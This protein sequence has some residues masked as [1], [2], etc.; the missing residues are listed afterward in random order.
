MGRN[1]LNELY[2]IRSIPLLE[3]TVRQLGF[4]HRFSQV[5][6]VLTTERY[7]YL[8]LQV[9]FT[10]D[11]TRPFVFSFKIEDQTTLVLQIPDQ[12][13]VSYTM[14]DSINIGSVRVCIRKSPFDGVLPVSDDLWQYTYTPAQSVALE[15]AGRLSASWAEEG[16]GI[17]NLTLTG[18]SPDKERDFLAGHIKNY[19]SYDLEQKNQRSLNTIKFI[20]EQLKNISDSLDFAERQLE[21]FKGRNVITNLEGEALRLY[22][23]IE[24]IE[25]QKTELRVSEKYYQHLQDYISKNDALDKVILPSSIG[26]EDEILT[27]L[28]SEMIKLQSEL[29]ITVQR[30]KI[31]NPLMVQKRK[32]IE[33]LKRSVLESIVNQ[34]SVNKIRVAFFDDQLRDLERQVGRLP[35]AERQLVNI[36]RNYSLSENLYVFLLQKRADAGI[37]KASNTTDIVEVNPPLVSGPI[38]P[39]TTR[40]NL[41]W[42]ALGLMLPL[43]VL[44][45]VEL[46]NTRVQS[47]EDIEKATSIPFLG[48]VGHKSGDQNLEVFQRP[49]SAISESFR[50]LRSNLNYFL[51][52]KEKG[53]FLIS[54]SVSGE[55]KTFTSVNLAAVFALSGRKT[56]I[57]GA[58]MRKPRIYSDFKLTNDFGLSNFLAGLMSFDEVVQRTAYNNLDLVSGGPVPPN[59]SELLL[60][61]QMKKF[62]DEARSRYDYVFIDSPPLALVTDAFVLSAV[63]DHT[64]FIIRQ[65]VTP[66]DLIRTIDDYYRAGKIS[67]I[68][69]VL[70]DIYKSGPGYGYGY[71]HGYGYGYGYG[72]GI[73][74]YGR[75]KRNNGHGYY[76]ET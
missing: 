44:T 57:V 59:P 76:E 41:I 26:I 35:T 52:K 68:S 4:E 66:K 64:L 23:K 67:H 18:P 34:R 30:G 9:G 22:Q 55:G 75:K 5:G 53:V 33:Q 54:S 27:N 63:V 3:R 43:V 20:N 42:G 73:Y 40:N 19:Q 6:K 13:A 48:G 28:L 32:E 62:L 71:G 25:L 31:E 74:G 60:S 47:R 39:N 12:E 50:A 21:L 56:L 37:T 1:Y 24:A 49:K 15:Y 70:N 14:N 8:P 29:T 61:E 65:N 58:D 10:G 38:S 11:R 36:K 16:A 72:Y 2:I 51:N 46:L 45:F 7:K 69:I 17:I